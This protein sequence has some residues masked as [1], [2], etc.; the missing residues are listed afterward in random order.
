MGNQKQPACGVFLIPGGWEGR[1]GHRMP[2]SERG[3][4][5]LRARKRAGA[6]VSSR[7]KDDDQLIL[8]Y[9]T[10]TLKITRISESIRCAYKIIFVFLGSG[11][12]R[13]KSLRY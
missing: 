1:G 13:R 3:E 6:R 5:G 12:K 2:H 8:C 4:S 11:Q 7:L 10:I 9:G